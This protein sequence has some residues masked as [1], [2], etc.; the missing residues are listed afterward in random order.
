MLSAA[1]RG[2]EH[3]IYEQLSKYFQ[4]NN[5]STKYQSGFRKLDSTVKSMLKATND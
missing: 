2:F 3:L 1:V 4:E 5:F